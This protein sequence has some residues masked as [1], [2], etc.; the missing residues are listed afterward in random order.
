MVRL[1]RDDDEIGCGPLRRGERGHR[2]VA[3]RRVAAVA[4]DERPA[5]ENGPIH[6]RDRHLVG[7][8]RQFDDHRVFGRREER[9]RWRGRQR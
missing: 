4:V 3:R 7:A 8:R 1:G 2:G 5:V 6:R 9:A